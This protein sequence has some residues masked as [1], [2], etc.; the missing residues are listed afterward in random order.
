[1]QKAVT[2]II[3]TGHCD[4]DAPKHTKAVHVYRSTAS[5]ELLGCADKTVHN[6]DSEELFLAEYNFLPLGRFST[7]ISP[8][9]GVYLKIKDSYCRS[10]T[11]NC[12]ELKYNENLFSEAS[13][14]CPAMELQT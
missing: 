14:H 1:M 9:A 11:N 12:S 2:T 5:P 10:V 7:V 13:V 4:F 8:K 3:A 6:D